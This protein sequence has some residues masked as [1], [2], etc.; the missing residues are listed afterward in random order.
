MP[1]GACM[2]PLN[3]RGGGGR[4]RPGWWCPARTRS[5]AATWSVVTEGE[6]VGRSVPRRVPSTLRGAGPRTLGGFVSY[7]THFPP[8]V[9]LAAPRPLVAAPRSGLA[10]LRGTDSIT[11][12]PSVTPAS[13]RPATTLRAEL[14]SGGAAAH[15]RHQ[16]LAVERLAPAV[17]AGVAEALEPRDLALAL[18][19]RR[20]IGRQRR[21]QRGDPV[22]QLQRE[23][24][25]R[26]AHELA[27]VLDRD[28]VV[29]PRAIWVLRLAHWLELVRSTGVISSSASM[30]AC[31]AVDMVLSS[32][33]TQP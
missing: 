15:R 25:R 3:A 30:R 8:R 16:P 13:P 18:E 31:V 27:H 6:R 11:R 26:G 14:S 2:E 12:F 7:K 28:L 21:D 1:S 20:V 33:M 22:A 5:V 24:R 32:P 23:V 29:R 10:H 19:A 17:L 9:A 4:I